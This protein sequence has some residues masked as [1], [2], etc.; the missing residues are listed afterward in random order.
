MGRG[1]FFSEIG[2]YGAQPG[3]I[4][5]AVLERRVFNSMGKVLSAQHTRA[6]KVETTTARGRSGGR[7]T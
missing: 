1:Y 6:P 5:L 4:E 3:S 2:Q 7:F